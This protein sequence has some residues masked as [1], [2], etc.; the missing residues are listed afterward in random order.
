[1][2]QLGIA[3]ERRPHLLERLGQLMYLTG[4]DWEQ[5]IAYLEQA[6]ALYEESGR[7]EDVARVHTHLAQHRSGSPHTRD[8]PR[9]LAH[10]RA[11]EA[12]LGQGP[13]REAMSEFYRGLATAASFGVRIGEGLDA[14]ARAMAIAGRLGDAA[15]RAGAAR[16]HGVLLCFAGR[17]GEGWALL[18]DA[19]AA[20]DRRNDAATAF[21]LATNLGSVAVRFLGDPRA[22]EGW[23]R[24][25]MAQPRQTEAAR[26]RQG[27]LHGL[28]EAAI[29]TG[30]LAGARALVPEA[31]RF[32]T[33]AE[34]HLALREG[35]WDRAES[36]WAERSDHCARAGDRLNGWYYHYLLAGKL[37]AHCAFERA[38]SLLHEALAI[39]VEG[40]HLPIE[41][42]ARAD[43][44]LGCALTGNTER[45]GEHLARCRAILTGGED[46]R[47]RAG[48]V[49]LAEAASAAATGQLNEAHRL[50]GEAVAI[51]QRYAL[52]WD[53]AEALV[54]WGRILHSAGQTSAGAAKLVAARAI[55]ERHGA[56][57]Q[58]LEVVNVTGSRKPSRHDSPGGYPNGLS[59]REVEVL[60]LIAAGHSN[61]EIADT[62]VLSVRTVERHI[63]NLYGKIGARGKADATAYALR[64][65]LA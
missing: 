24:R 15:L 32:N 42:A 57:G 14:S 3:D 17:L 10:Y 49:L 51:F 33:V 43:L 27:L 5:G 47:G 6:L 55:L 62:F 13:E 22:A 25:E 61:K 16:A 11:A 52:P 4:L 60:R 20:A 34:F 9:A 21:A 35:E 65:D 26:Q 39:G 41:L 7:A 40:G 46:W 54:S 53:E 64:H 38:E 59:P 37:R 30:D 1:M 44:A 36:L 12:V 45:A 48:R 28:S 19:W 8:I 18:E 50:F 58:W 31:S 56:G 23:L 2:E 63:T 29:L